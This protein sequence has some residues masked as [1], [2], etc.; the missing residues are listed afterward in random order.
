[1][2]RYSH[3]KTHLYSTHPA[4]NYTVLW[5]MQC[6]C[7]YCHL[8]TTTSDSFCHVRQYVHQMMCQFLSFERPTVCHVTLIF[9][10]I[11]SSLLCFPDCH[12]KTFPN[13]TALYIP[14]TPN[15]QSSTLCFPIIHYT[16]KH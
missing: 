5:L 4:E 6:I 13:Q 10:I 2:D 14:C 15:H 8:L 12:F 11:C 16:N 7:K 1:M 9:I 3:C